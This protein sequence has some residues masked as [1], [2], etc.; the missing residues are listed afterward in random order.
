M[1]TTPLLFTALGCVRLEV[2]DQEWAFF[3]EGFEAD[4]LDEVRDALRTRLES[5]DLA[6]F[7]VHE[8]AVRVRL[9]VVGEG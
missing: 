6:A 4:A 9:A 2:D 1:R 3:T 8:M 7:G 5:L